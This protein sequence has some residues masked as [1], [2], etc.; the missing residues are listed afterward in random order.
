MDEMS[1]GWGLGLSIVADLV[2]VSGGDLTFG[3][4][5]LG[6]LAARARFP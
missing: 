4:S 3:R 1:K 5:E 2:E 6:G